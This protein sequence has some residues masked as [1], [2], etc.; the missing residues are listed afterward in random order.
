MQFY[1]PKPCEA[2]YSLPQLTP[3]LTWEGMKAKSNVH[4]QLRGVVD[5]ITKL[6]SVGF[7]RTNKLQFLY[8]KFE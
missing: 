5:L 3:I 6:S 8:P 4:L 7:E 2:L 1:E